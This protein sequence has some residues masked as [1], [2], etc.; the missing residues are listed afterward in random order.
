VDYNT[1]ERGSWNNGLWNP[2]PEAP[3]SKEPEAPTSIFVA[4]LPWRTPPGFAH[5]QRQYFEE[6]V[7][8]EQRGQQAAAKWFGRLHT[9]VSVYSFLAAAVITIVS[10]LA[11][12][13]KVITIL[14]GIQTVVLAMNEHFRFE[15]RNTA[16]AQAAVQLNDLIVECNMV[17][18]PE[19][20]EKAQGPVLSAAHATAALRKAINC[21]QKKGFEIPKCLQGPPVN[22]QPPPP[23]PATD[24]GSFFRS[25]KFPSPPLQPARTRPAGP[26]G[27]N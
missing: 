18:T 22:I 27:V 26:G 9:A 1:G 23:Q 21:A 25:K 12:D 16:H 11:I 17:H 19:F 10:V 3:W 4:G 5:L 13:E 2:H 8:S 14:A 7:K 24:S 20:H 6:T 15:E